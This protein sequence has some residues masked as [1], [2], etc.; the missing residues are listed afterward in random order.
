MQSSLLR[1]R[2]AAEV[3]VREMDGGRP[4]SE[5]KIVA[6]APGSR[7]LVQASRPVAGRRH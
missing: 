7:L 1:P 3:I 6:L 2:P 5:G 4:L